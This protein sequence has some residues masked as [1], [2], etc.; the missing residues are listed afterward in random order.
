MANDNLTPLWRF[1]KHRRGYFETLDPLR[2]LRNLMLGL[3]AVILGVGITQGFSLTFGFP[4]GAGIARAAT[5][6]EPA[7][8]DPLEQR[9]K[10]NPRLSLQQELKLTEAQLKANELVI[11][12][13]K[14]SESSDYFGS[15]RCYLQLRAKAKPEGGLLITRAQNVFKRGART[16]SL[17]FG[18]A[19]WAESLNCYSEGSAALSVKEFEDAMGRILTVDQ[20]ASR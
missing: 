9:F 7:T 16:L 18:K 8:T 11:Q 14:L 10:V 20:R 6:S 12:G 5:G 13:G 17:E 4:H 1:K 2:L 15:T 19:S 3:G